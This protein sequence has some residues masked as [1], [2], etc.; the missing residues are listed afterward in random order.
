MAKRSPYMSSMADDAA[1]LIY[2]DGYVDLQQVKKK[3]AFAS[4]FAKSSLLAN[5]EI[6]AALHA[7]I[8]AEAQQENQQ[9]WLAHYVI[10]E[11]AMRFF[12]DFQPALSEYMAEGI[13]SRHLPV[14]LHLFASAAEEVL[15]FFDQQQ[16]P[17]HIVDVRVRFGQQYDHRT[18][19]NFIVDDIAVELV[20]F[21]QD[22][23]FQRPISPLTGKPAK[24]LHGKKL[25]NFVNRI[26][27]ESAQSR[28]LNHH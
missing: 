25:Q 16:I 3:V 9:Q 8:T 15:M 2:R 22:E 6:V 12:Q 28:S 20:V 18:G 27:T 14:T 24:R 19:V 26:K 10:A 21:T 1:R 23:Q 4:G 17:H 7:Y 5:E 11:A 13:A